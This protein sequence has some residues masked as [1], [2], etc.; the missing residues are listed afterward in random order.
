MGE[1]GMQPIEQR[2]TS[3]LET[4]S[5]PRQHDVCERWRSVDERAVRG[6]SDRVERRV[7][8]RRA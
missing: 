4:Y 6:R 8:H 1:C 2:G 7:W 5:A 3:D